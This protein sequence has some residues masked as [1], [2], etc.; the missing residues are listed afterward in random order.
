M[1]EPQ[2]F[3]TTDKEIPK[4]TFHWW[5]GDL[6]ELES[7]IQTIVMEKDI[8]A[9][10][11]Y[12]DVNVPE[13]MVSRPCLDKERGVYNPLVNM[14]VA[15]TKY[16]G[17]AGGTYGNARGR[18]HRGLDLSAEVGTPIFAMIN[19]EISS[20]P[21]VIEQP[22]RIGTEGK[23]PPGYLGDDDGAGNRFY[24][25]GKLDGKSVKIGYWH[26]QANCP[27]AINPRTGQ[28]YKAGDKVYA[29]D[30]IGYTG[31]TGNAYNTFRNHLHLY[32]S[33]NNIEADPE[34]IINGKLDWQNNRLYNPQIIEIKCND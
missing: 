16:N 4:Y 3:S 7:P 15:P 11:Y 12:F 6:P 21:F 17:L 24:I 5:T 13:T 1:V 31:K 14:E 2:V 32:C 23:Y 33:I 20:W 10:A 19:G 26:L 18:H 34:E 8:T 28:T 30:L 22:D 25:E 27:V 29:G 9:T